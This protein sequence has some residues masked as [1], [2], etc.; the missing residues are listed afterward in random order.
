MSENT[1]GNYQIETLIGEGGMG[2]VFKGRDVLLEREVALKVLRPEL[3]RQPQ[4]VERF[5]HEAITLARLD[6]PY[7]A[8]L[9]AL[10]PHGTDFVM[11]MEFVRGETLEALLRRHGA[12]TLSQSLRL[13]SQVLEGIA[14]AHQLGIVHRD[15][16]PANLMLT[17]GG[18]IKVMDFGI[19]RLLGK[20]RQTRT[21]RIV[22]TLEYMAPEHVRGQE[23]DARSDI[24]ALGVVLY[25]LLTGRV[26]FRSDSEYDLM[27]AHLEEPPPPPRRFAQHVPPAIEHLILR[28]LAKDP[29][30]RFQTALDL[31]AALIDAARHSSVSLHPSPAD[32]MPMLNEPASTTVP[33]GADWQASRGSLAD[34][35][36]QA[37]RVASSSQV[38]LRKPVLPQRFDKRH[39]AAAATAAVVLLGGATW[40]FGNRAATPKPA[41]APAV[42]EAPTPAEVSSEPVVPPS[43]TAPP[44]A[45]APHPAD[46]IHIANETPTTN[47]TVAPPPPAPRRSKRSAP[48]AYP[49]SAAPPA[50]LPTRVQ[51]APAAPRAAPVVTANAEEERK[52]EKEAQKRAEK[53]REAERTL[54]GI[55]GII[56]G[57]KDIWSSFKSDKKKDKKP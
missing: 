14:H 17:D 29:A 36:I 11:V 25:E 56:G 15:L 54:K 23:T 6:H 40:F 19:A 8:R 24:Y 50:A 57:A 21:G 18:T 13:F 16:K 31:H 9:H 37:T 53:E 4:L 34:Q 32:V 47:A 38:S 44:Q 1:I 43:F 48:P 42:V 55:G 52:R 27:H 49:P 35:L 51:P 2:T 20:A 45:G 7:V 30:D 28:A 10:L 33:S 22:G 3:A 5:R 26:P 41:P 12:L 46:S 39:Y